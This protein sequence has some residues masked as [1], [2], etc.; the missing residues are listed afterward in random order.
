MVIK[1]KSSM[2]ST[3]LF[4]AVSL[5]LALLF[6]A[7][8]LNLFAFSFRQFVGI[9]DPEAQNT[10]N[11]LVA[12]ANTVHSGDFYLINILPE[13]KALIF[14]VKASEDHPTSFT[15]RQN[16]TDPSK[17]L[18]LITAKSVNIPC[19]KKNTCLC[20]ARLKSISSENFDIDKVYSC[21]VIKSH[22]KKDFCIYRDAGDPQLVKLLVK[23]TKT[24]NTLSLS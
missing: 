23:S 11:R 4:F 14:S 17:T 12:S 3:M 13:K 5:I 24:Y 6:L 10:F 2:S 16:T 1:K 8:I 15:C 20:L 9:P 7:P 21:K 18:S 22:I 19:G